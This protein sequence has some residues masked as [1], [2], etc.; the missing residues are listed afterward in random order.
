[1]N[2]L[3]L[4]A[5]LFLVFSVSAAPADL[6]ADGSPDPSDSTPT[7]APVPPVA[8]SISTVAVSN[9]GDLVTTP[10]P[11]QPVPANNGTSV[12]T[13]APINPNSTVTQVSSTTFAT[14]TQSAQGASLFLSLVPI[15]L[16]LK[17]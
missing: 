17:L 7:A 13:V 4:F 11:T 15:A 8:T 12:T 14:T 9:N 16:Y 2:S 6:A 1:M 5:A 3:T 10:A